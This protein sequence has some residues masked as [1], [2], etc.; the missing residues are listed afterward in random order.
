MGNPG[1]ND[2]ALR[3]AYQKALDARR[4]SGRES[5]VAPEAMLRC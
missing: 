4:V 3:E 2:E 1:V 5:C